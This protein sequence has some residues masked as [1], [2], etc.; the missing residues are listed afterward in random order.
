MKV[1]SPLLSAVAHAHRL[2]SKQL[3]S[4]VEQDQE[5]PEGE[6]RYREQADDQVERQF[7]VEGRIRERLGRR[8]D[9]YHAILEGVDTQEL[10]PVDIEHR[11]PR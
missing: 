9:T 2:A 8:E 4:G 10:W 3:P 6:P 1:A 11:I 5:H 7:E